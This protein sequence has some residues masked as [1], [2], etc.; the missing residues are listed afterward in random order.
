MG[1]AMNREQ[2][3]RERLYQASIAIAR[4]ML[5]KN[6]IT[7]DEY[8][9]IETILLKKYRPLLGGLQVGKMQKTLEK[10]ALLSDR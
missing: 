9:Q 2:F 6:F 5:K 4:T 1:D 10:I 8:F 3:N 7:E